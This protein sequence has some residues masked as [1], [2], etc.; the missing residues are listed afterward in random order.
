[1]PTVVATVGGST[2]NSYVEV[3][4]ADTFFDERVGSTAWT[5]D[6]SADDKARA[7]IQATRRID[8]EQ[9]VGYPVRPLTDRAASGTTQALQWPRYNAEAPDGWWYAQ[10]VIPEPIK[11]ATMMLARAIVAGEFQAADT[12][13]EGFEEVVVDVLKVKPVKGHR[14]GGLPDEVGRELRGLLTT[15]SSSTFQ[16]MRG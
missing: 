9:F 15:P 5:V 16:I 8:Q 3:A 11:R 13:L 4:E 10:D 1:M 14:S 2:S 6:A 7:V 12:G